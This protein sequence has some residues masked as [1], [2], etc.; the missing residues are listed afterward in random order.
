MR[1]GLT[2]KSR[3]KAH[4]LVFEVIALVNLLSQILLAPASWRFRGKR[5][6][7][8]VSDAARQRSTRRFIEKIQAPP[9]G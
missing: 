6:L 9:G 8:S 3:S 1:L 7:T 4:F 5:L 2:C